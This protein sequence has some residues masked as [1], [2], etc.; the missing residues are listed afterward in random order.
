MN[1]TT[2]TFLV[3]VV[4]MLALGTTA[5]MAAHGPAGAFRSLARLTVSPA[6]N[7]PME[8]GW[9]CRAQRDAMGSPAFSQ[10][11]GRSPK[12]KRGMGVCVTHMAV[13]MNEGKAAQVEHRVM[14]AVHAC[15]ADG[16][17]HS[18]SFRRRFG[19]TTKSS[20]ALGRCVR[21][22]SGIGALG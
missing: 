9:L 2:R 12:S 21:F 3:S 8:P 22:R 16:R 18:A 14:L 19:K 1:R 11:W 15:K 7:D 13:A 5:S 6:P 10:A 17:H 4:A 20:N